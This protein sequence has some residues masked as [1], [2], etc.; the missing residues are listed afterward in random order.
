[1]KRR[2][3]FS[4][5]TVILLMLILVESVLYFGVREYYYQGMSSTFQNHAD[6][7]SVFLQKYE[8]NEYQLLN[9]DQHSN[10]IMNSL[11]YEGAQ[12]ELINREGTVMMSN[13][14]FKQEKRQHLP[15]SVLEGETNYE[16]ETNSATG[17]KVLATYTPL[18]YQGQVIAAL[19]YTSSLT[20]V[21]KAIHHVMYL[22]ISVGLFISLI[23]FIISLK[24]AN[25]IVTPIHE[26]TRDAYKMGKT[27]FKTRIKEDYILEIG[28]LSE[29]LN[30]MADE[31]EK[32]DQMKNDFISSIS[33]ELRTPL[34]GIK[35]WIETIRTSEVLT[36]EEIE[37]GMNIISNET[38][39]LISLVEQL[40]DFSRFQSKRI[41][42]EKTSIPLA[43]FIEEVTQQLRV[44]AEEKHLTFSIE[45]DDEL[46]IMAD[47]SRLKQVL[48]NVY[49]NAIKY[50]KE[51]SSIHTSYHEVEK[52]III[53]IKDY[54]IGISKLDLPLV[55][56]T[57]YQS[58]INQGGS[59]LGLAISNE[60]I[61]LHDG[62]ITISSELG[63][64]TCVTIT[65]PKQT[66]NT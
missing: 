5:M 16:A 12:L 47:E 57:F 4:F 52:E 40:L 8:F 27:N 44:K 11:E 50:S 37:L 19:K 38:N 14:G 66:C 35:G 53:A 34:T 45:G 55:M 20:E 2:V 24:L 58:N 56:Q 10:E 9:I 61:D 51:Q 36:E 15:P 18:L 21:S 39:R 23:V 64:G 7:S 62:S 17:E 32:T 60:I 54:G 3:I 6:T 65:L 33:H 49:D 25:S 22:A 41:V 46:S 26:I 42:L 59:G 29:T 1:M 28:Q 63:K 48:I 43:P 31:I 13:Y 30:Y